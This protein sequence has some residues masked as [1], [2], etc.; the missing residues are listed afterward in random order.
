[1]SFNKSNSTC[2]IKAVSVK[3]RHTCKNCLDNT[4]NSI[5]WLELGYRITY[6]NLIYPAKNEHFYF[7]QMIY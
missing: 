4:G 1:M 5:F 6:K 3:L 7:I 2:L